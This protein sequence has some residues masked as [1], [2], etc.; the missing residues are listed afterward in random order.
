MRPGGEP[1]RS[2]VHA[3]LA[4]LAMIVTA[5]AGAAP[6]PDDAL[7]VGPTFPSEQPPGGAPAAPITAGVPTPAPIGRDAPVAP[8]AEPPTPSRA[9]PVDPDEQLPLG[10]SR[11]PAAAPRAT[12]SP[13]P[14]A[15]DLGPTLTALASVVGLIVLIGGAMK[16]ARRGSGGGLATSRAP[17]GILEVL[18][19]YPLPGGP[20]LVLLRADRRVLLLSQARASRLSG[21][22]ISTL[23]E[24]EDVDDVASILAQARDAREESIS[25]RFS[26][27][28]TGFAAEHRVAP[29]AALGA[30]QVESEVVDAE[31]MD[32]GRVVAGD[33]IGA[34]PGPARSSAS[35]TLRRR[36]EGLRAWEG[37]TA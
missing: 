19:R 31:G 21:A 17:S 26:S 22:S 35:S 7:F 25:A 3:A 9:T 12:R 32:A 36:L 4:A 27:L 13:G 28:L 10:P 30:D 34:A 23:A 11:S 20:T 29:G 16:L 18:G 33:V 6:N 24:F 5:P 14:E 15:S 2:A 1:S 8:A 37:A